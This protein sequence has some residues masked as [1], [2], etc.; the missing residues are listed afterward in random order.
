VNA[1][2]FTLSLWAIRWVP[3]TLSAAAIGGF[4]ATDLAISLGGLVGTALYVT[5]VPLIVAA[6]AMVWRRR[7]LPTPPWLVDGPP[8]PALSTATSAR[9]PSLLWALLAGAIPGLTAA[10]F[11]HLHRLA[12]GR[13]ITDDERI[14]RY[15]FWLA[16]GTLVALTVSFI[17][18][19]AIPRSG[20]AIGLL[21]GSVAAFVAALGIVAANTFLIGNILDLSFWWTTIVG[22][23]TL[24]LAGYLLLLPLALAGWPAPWRNV[25]GWL[26]AGMTALASGMVAV[27]LFT[28]AI[29]AP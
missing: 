27:V 15:L 26:L 19:A 23:T 14:G 10:V 24:W 6:A 29:A 20:P 22:T 1:L 3:V 16:M 13:P 2:I 12:V 28:V 25:P 9:D 7:H 21:T 4:G 8:P 5:A 18:L 17:T 11:V